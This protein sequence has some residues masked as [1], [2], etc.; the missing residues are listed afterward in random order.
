MCSL[1]CL[2]FAQLLFDSLHF[3][4]GVTL[5]FLLASLK[6]RIEFHHLLMVMPDDAFQTDSITHNIQNFPCGGM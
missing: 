2:D 5:D 6:P 3:A 4:E 1:R